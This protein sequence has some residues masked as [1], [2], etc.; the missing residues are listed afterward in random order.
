MRSRP[1]GPSKRR[2]GPVNPRLASDAAYTARMAVSPGE[3][4]FHCDTGSECT[5]DSDT[6]STAAIA[7]ALA[8]WDSVSPKSLPDARAT[9]MASCKA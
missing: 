3:K 5:Q 4:P 2:I 7:T 8:I 6:L 9:D 1:L